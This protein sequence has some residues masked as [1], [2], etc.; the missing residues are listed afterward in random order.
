MLID[1]IIASKIDASSDEDIVIE[2]DDFVMRTLPIAMSDLDPS[3]QQST[4]SYD[5]A[6]E[7]DAAMGMTYMQSKK[8][9]QWALKECRRSAASRG[10]DLTLTPS[11][12]ANVELYLQHV[13][14]YFEYHIDDFY[15]FS[16]RMIIR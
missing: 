4:W 14:A 6:N 13:E 11:Y 5:Q 3:Y 9:S 7:I 8:E 1:D 12:H 10:V 2:V 15:C 16:S